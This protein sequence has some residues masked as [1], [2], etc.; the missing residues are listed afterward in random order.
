VGIDQAGKDDGVI[1]VL[2]RCI[3]GSGYTGIRTDVMDP[4][5]RADQQRTSLD[6]RTFNREQPPRG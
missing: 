4:A 1:K 5:I 2:D 3:W 6:R